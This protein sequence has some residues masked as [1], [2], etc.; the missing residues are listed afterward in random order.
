MDVK[1]FSSH[2]GEMAK[3][4]SM[5]KHHLAI[6]SSLS[7]SPLCGGGGGAQREKEGHLYTTT[8]AVHGAETSSTLGFPPVAP[9]ISFSESLRADPRQDL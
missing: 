3:K 5:N 1:V 7:P 4:L 6:W 8:C 9:C 2:T